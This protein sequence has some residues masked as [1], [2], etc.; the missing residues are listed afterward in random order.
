MFSQYLLK[1][2][3]QLK[4]IQDVGLYCVTNMYL[5]V[6]WSSYSHKFKTILLLSTIDP[7]GIS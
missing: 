3:P 2:F 5:D 4:Q 1:A 6:S 7:K